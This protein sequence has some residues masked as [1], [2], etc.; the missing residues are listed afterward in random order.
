MVTKF[1]GA[2]K[3]VNSFKERKYLMS[4]SEIVDGNKTQS[5]ICKQLMRAVGKLHENHFSVCSFFVKL[6]TIAVIYV[7]CV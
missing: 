7:Q 1:V 3:K 2:A 4:T 5:L 6:L